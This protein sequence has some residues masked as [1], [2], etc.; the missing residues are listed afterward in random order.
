V[1][2]KFA[3]KAAPIST[4]DVRK[5]MNKCSLLQNT[6]P[7]T[8]VHIKCL[9]VLMIRLNPKIGFDISKTEVDAFNILFKLWKS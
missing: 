9:V 8:R 6:V 7:S 2:Q 4:L 3:R 1:K 5:I